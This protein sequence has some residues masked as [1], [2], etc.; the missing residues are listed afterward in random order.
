MSGH[1]TASA[2]RFV[3]AAA[4]ALLL[5]G[6]AAAQAPA[7]AASTL[8]QGAPKPILEDIRDIRGPRSFASPWTLAILGAATALIGAGAYGAW[9][10]QRQRRMPVALRHSEVALQRLERARA[11]LLSGD[12]RRFSI[13]ASDAVRDYLEIHFGVRAAH[14]TTQEFLRDQLATGDRRLAAH[15]SVLKEFLLLCDLAKFAGWNLTVQ[16]MEAMYQSACRFVLDTAA[17]V[18][19][20]I[21]PTL[22]DAVDP[23]TASVEDS[24]VSLP[25]T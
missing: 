11:L 7:L 25:S 16:S 19:T 17:E 21:D 18:P 14:R 4:V 22:S 9:R 13:E 15:T 3:A 2:G 8:P 10:W 6:F 5:S 24:Y 1:F 12:G 20:H 23:S